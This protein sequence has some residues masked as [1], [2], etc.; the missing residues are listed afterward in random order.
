MLKA[1]AM[2][3]SGLEAFGRLKEQTMPS[4]TRL[5]VEIETLLGARSAVF[6]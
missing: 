2:L 1:G 5:G 6:A 4:D 3:D